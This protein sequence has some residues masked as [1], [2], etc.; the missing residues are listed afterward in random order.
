MS[1]EKI[2]YRIAEMNQAFPDAM[3]SGHDHLIPRMQA[4]EKDKHVLAAAV[5][6]RS[7]VLVTENDKDFNPP[8]TGDDAMRVERTSKFLNRLM[9]EEPE[10]VI[11]TLQQM[12]EQNRYEPRSMPALIDKMAKRPELADFARRVNAAVPPEQRGTDPKLGGQIS[13]ALDGVAPAQGAAVPPVRAPQARS[14]Q[15]GPEQGPERG[16][17]RGT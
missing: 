13:I 16:P 6:S 17:G 3:V 15:P 4:D 5:H 8:A 1:A 11:S 14:T 7:D 12:V 2:D 9:D 10:Q